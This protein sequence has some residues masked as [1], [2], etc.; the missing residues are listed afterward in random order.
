MKK[1]RVINLL[2]R[3]KEFL[4]KSAVENNSILLDE[5]DGTINRINK[6]F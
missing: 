3:R 4:K 6:H 5:I 1:N 2:L